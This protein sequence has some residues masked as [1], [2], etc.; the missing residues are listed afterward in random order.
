MTK[1]GHSFLRLWTPSCVYCFLGVSIVLHLPAVEDQDSQNQQGRRID[2]GIRDVLHHK[3]VLI[4]DLDLRM[5]E[6]V[7][8]IEVAEVRQQVV[9][10]LARVAHQRDAVGGQRIRHAAEV[11]DQE[12][13]E[14]QEEIDDRG[15]ER[16]EED[17]QRCQ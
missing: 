1:N 15:G 9:D 11:T 13:A 4:L 8:D 10:Q 12:D 3:G 17:R 16:R 2:E 6:G 14:R 5:D 7:L